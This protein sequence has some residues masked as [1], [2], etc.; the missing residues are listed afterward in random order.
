MSLNLVK[1]LSAVAVAAVC[2]SCGSGGY[3]AST[4]SAPSSTSASSTSASATSSALTISIA[5]R[6]GSQ[7][8]SPNPA[9][10]GGQMVVFRNNDSIPHRVV[11]NDGT[12]DTGIIQPGGS[13]A[14]VLMPA[15]GSNY[16]CS[17]HPDMTGSVNSS[18]G[19]AAPPDSSSPSPGSGY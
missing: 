1:Y 14:A 8:F 15:N 16:H 18:S 2:A 6:N 17:I 5:S 13:S 19:A 3:G 4:P 12:V 11:L 7:S 10:A 9:S